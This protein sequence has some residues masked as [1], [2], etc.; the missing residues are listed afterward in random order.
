MEIRISAIEARNQHVQM[1]KAWETSATRRL[2]IA[3]I[4]YMTASILFCFVIPQPNWY[5]AAI[6]PV[7]GYLLS[8]L[9]LP[10]LKRK[11]QEKYQCS[12]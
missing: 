1:D 2:T 5:I 9:S 8:T 11:W 6:I 12:L 4:T 7:T 10:W 3:V